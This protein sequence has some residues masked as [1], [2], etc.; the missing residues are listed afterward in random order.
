MKGKCSDKRGGPPN[1]RFLD[2]G[3]ECQVQV[4]I[5]VSDLAEVETK[6]TGIHTPILDIGMQT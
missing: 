5:R 4:Y 3:M 1:L 6:D 2:S